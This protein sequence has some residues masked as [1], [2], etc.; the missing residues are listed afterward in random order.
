MTSI[1]DRLRET[2]L[3]EGLAEQ[4]F[5][6]LC[7]STERVEVAAG[8]VVVR[9]GEPGN[10][11]YVLE[12]GAVQ[13]FTF[14]EDGG[15]IVLAK[16]GPGQHFGEQALV[17]GRPDRRNAHVRAFSK[18]KLL[19]VTKEAFQHAL[20]LDSPLRDRLERL[21][22]EQ[23]RANLATQFQLFRSLQLE[24]GEASLQPESFD[25]G[26]TIFRQG[27]FGDRVYFILS[28]TARVYQEA[29]GSPQLVVR[30]SM[31]QCFGE[32]ALLR[33]APRSATVVAEG[34][35]IALSLNGQRFLELHESTPEL[36]DYMQTLQTVY[37]L[38][39]R[40]FATQHTGRFMGSNAIT[41]MYHLAD[42]RRMLASRVVGGD[43]YNMAVVG[44]GGTGPPRRI[45]YVDPETGDDR[46]LALA[47]DGQL[48]GATV[49]GVWEQL[50]Q[51]HHMILEGRTLKPW[52]EDIFRA[53][54][55]LRL[56]ED[57]TFFEDSEPICSCLHVTRGA[58]D[59]C[60]REGCNTAA[61]LTERTGAGSVCGAC[62]PRLRELCGCAE[63]TP[64][65]VTEQIRVS[66]TVR[67]F[68]LTP[69]SGELVAPLPG[70]HV[71]VQARI[72]N[73]WVQRPYTL[74]SDCTE[75]GSYQITVKREPRGLLSGWLFDRCDEQ[76]LLRVSAPLGTFTLA[77]D[78]KAPG[79]CFVGGIGVTPAVAMAR[80]LAAT[81]SPHRL[82]IDLSSS[83]PETLAYLTKIAEQAKAQG[84]TVS[85]R[86]TSEAGHVTREDVAA[87]ARELPGAIFFICGPKGFQEHVEGLLRL[88]DVPA[89][90][91]RVET[92]TPQGD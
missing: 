90:R 29:G 39:R 25:A 66:D 55:T 71:V 9:E 42:G 51:I 33:R 40:G 37:V 35:L 84:L 77:M 69:A 17:P 81:G 11:L 18:T 53:R 48:A 67:S 19:R 26:T 41:T 1:A 52:Q 27:E 72:G 75:C 79:A 46:E 4:E 13:V 59:Q 65:T 73:D 54:G 28:G 58:L 22:E 10:G 12:H 82:H 47:A 61:E 68:R 14:G 30:L 63:W 21:G 83:E 86:L 50:G 6:A 87:V 56:E 92:F 2:G 38:P 60:I 20:S 70:Q 85:T 5:D 89:D 91:V 24:S 23:L 15:E 3:F 31:G 78:S 57:S 45:R 34:P 64:V 74:T 16:L 88:L 62:I 32:L 80:S 7:G 8:D 36:R 76:S 43:T 49:C 44:A